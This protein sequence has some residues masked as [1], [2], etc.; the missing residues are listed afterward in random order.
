MINDS[1]ERRVEFVARGDQEIQ[2]LVAVLALGMCR[3]VSSGAVSA[4]YACHRL[5]GP[6]LISRAHEAG[7]TRDFVEVLNLASELEAVEQLAPDAF[8]ASLADIEARLLDVL[9]AIA[10]TV[11]EGE[12]WLLVPS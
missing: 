11:V 10:P 5:F 12:K 8:Q 1:K 9:R 7:A 6:A 2:R 4:D 3:A